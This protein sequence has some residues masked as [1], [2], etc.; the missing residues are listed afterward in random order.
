MALPVWGERRHIAVHAVTAVPTV[1]TPLAVLAA[2]ALAGQPRAARAQDG[3]SFPTR[4]VRIVVPFP[5]GGTN[6]ILGRLFAGKL[7]E[8]MGWTVVVENRTGAGSAIGANSVATA[9]PDGTTLL[10]ASPSHP[11][12]GVVQKLPYDPVKSFSPVALL[13]TGPSAVTVTP[14][15][16]V[17]TLA[18]L[19]ALAKAKPGALS[20]GSAGA[21]TANHFVSEYFNQTAK[22][23][24]LHVAY[25]GGGPAINDVMAGHIQDYHAGLA[26][27]LPLI[28]AGKLKSLAITSRERS[29]AAPEL[30]PVANTLPGFGALNW[31]GMLTA[32]NTPAALVARLNG[33]VNTVLRDP[34]IVKRL[35]SEGIQ[36]TPVTP[37]YVG[38]L[39]ADDVAK[40][41][42]VGKAA[43]ITAQ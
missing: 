27:L 36:P 14:T 10:V 29:P 8:R 37:E 35:E 24:V 22:I 23:N 15:L 32:P 17:N 38:K 28:R 43:G 7:T 21:G 19:I 12:L 11:I 26:S 39:I 4:P 30:P 6:D 5:P 40:W 34:D 33:A 9:A 20:Y 18:E 31:Y 1:P 2:A 16:P 41:A 3:A 13:G 42:T 25:K